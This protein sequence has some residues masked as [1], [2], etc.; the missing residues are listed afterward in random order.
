MTNY[1]RRLC[2]HLKI[3]LLL[4]NRLLS[5][6]EATRDAIV[7]R[8]V[9]TLIGLQRAHARLIEDAE[10]LA[11]ERMEIS[12]RLLTDAGRPDD[13]IEGMITLSTLAECCPPEMSITL[14]AIRDA[15][16][17]VAG[18]V[19]EMN[20]LN[21]QLLEN[22]IEYIGGSLETLVRVATNAR[23]AIGGVAPTP[24]SLLLNKA[25]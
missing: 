8:K 17:E 9:D 6:A 10:T 25:A 20:R 11:A 3:E 16:V 22:E 19:Q 4:Q 18:R 23:T 21:R 1:A 12:R 15:L 13:E 14:S 5:N 7:A 2:T 24:T